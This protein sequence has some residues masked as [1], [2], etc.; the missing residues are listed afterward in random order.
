M[1]CRQCVFDVVLGLRLELPCLAAWTL[2]VLL[3]RCSGALLSAY[4][5]ILAPGRVSV[6]AENCT[7]AGERMDEAE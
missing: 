6:L 1:S 7:T 2:V 4:Y 3:S 5:W